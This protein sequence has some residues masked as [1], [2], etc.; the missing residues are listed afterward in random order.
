MNCDKGNY[1]CDGGYVNRVLNWGKRKGFVPEECIPYEGEPME[2][3]EE[4]LVTN[5]CRQVNNFY[6]VIDFCLAVEDVG[7]KK[8]LIKNGPVVAQM[9]AYTD[10][11]TYKEGVYHRTE[12]SF[13]F[14]GQHIVK[15]LG[16]DKGKDGSDYWIVEN[17]WGQ[18][19]GDNGYVFVSAADK[20]ISIDYYAIGVAVYPMTM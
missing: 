9:S 15:I 6:K 16:W 4:H 13:K 3:E 17:S 2:C 11:L 8:E 18:D 19:W 10:F 20:S 1:Q 7:I 12:D 5:E 14:N